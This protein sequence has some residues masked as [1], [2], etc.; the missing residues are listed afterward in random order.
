MGTC[1]SVDSTLVEEGVPIAMKVALESERDS[2]TWS[3]L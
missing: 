2:L 3:W 1:L